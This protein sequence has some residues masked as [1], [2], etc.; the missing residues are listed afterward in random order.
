MPTIS[1]KP[2]IALPPLPKTW[3]SLGRAFLDMHGKMGKMPCLVDSSGAKLDY[4]E[5]LLRTMVLARALKRELGDEKYIGIYLPPCAPAAIVNF[6]VTLLGKVPVNLNY[7]I[8]KEVLDSCVKLA[9]IKTTITSDKAL[10]KFPAK[11]EGR[12]ISLEKLPARITKAD[13][14]IGFFLARFAPMWLRSL[15]LPGLQNEKPDNI[16]TV[17]FTSGSTGIPKG[18]VLSHHNIL[19]NIWGVECHLGLEHDTGMLG[20]LPF[21]HSFGFTVTL[22]AVQIL[23]KMVA[24]HHNP[25][26]SR[27]IGKLLEQN[28]VSLL[29]ATPTFMGN[30][31]QR[32]EKKQFV[33]V[34]RV[35][36]GAEKLPQDL[37]D[38]IMSILNIKTI[39][40]YGCT[41]LSP[42]VSLNVD[43]SLIKGDGKEVDGMRA[44]SVGRP[45][46]GTASKTVDPETG[47]DLAAGE[48]GLLAFKGPN[49]M[50]GYLHNEKATAEAI[51]DGWYITGDIGRIDEDGFIFI[52]D[53]LARFAKIGGEMVPMKGV[54]DAIRSICELPPNSVAVVKL[55]DK[56]RGERVVVVHVPIPMS[57]REVV[58]KLNQ[59]SMPKLWIP[60][61]RSFIEVETIPILGSGKTDYKGIELIAESAAV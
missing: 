24:L 60:D 45:I 34:R 17:I 51:V 18:V 26:E 20:I 21:F 41:E 59:S 9:E 8:G 5:T 50:K 11:P 47:Q 39:E 27:T 35:L 31:I 40:G 46:P 33:H 6:A 16:A 1:D 43:H 3:K 48:T 2:D 49:V 57:P 36:L 55:P 38:T 56:T 22:W 4:R 52:T 14:G 37:S 29:V 12:L 19:S 53:R 30:Y 54:E 23:G 28:P 25:L 13:K 61:S 44:G 42:V 32:L 15:M 10:L 7:T 58:D